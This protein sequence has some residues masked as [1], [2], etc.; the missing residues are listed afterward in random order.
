MRSA[1]DSIEKEGDGQ[2]VSA[3]ARRSPTRHELGMQPIQELPPDRPRRP[4]GM[5]HGPSAGFGRF[6]RGTSATME[7][8]GIVEARP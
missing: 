3:T 1:L 5:E 6:E 2:Q 7:Q 4:A 8:A